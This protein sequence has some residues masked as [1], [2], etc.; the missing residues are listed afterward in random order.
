MKKTTTKSTTVAK[1]VRTTT[2]G[3]VVRIQSTI[4]KS[5]GGG[6]PKHSYVG[7]MQ[8]VVAQQDAGQQSK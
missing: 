8:K 2:A 5:N 4:A 6:V 3:D 1:P 7:R